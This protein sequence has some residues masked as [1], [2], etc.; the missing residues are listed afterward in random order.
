MLGSSIQ[1]AGGDQLMTAGMTVTNDGTKTT[2]LGKSGDYNRVGDAGTTG[3]SLASEDDLMITGKLEVDGVA[4]FNGAVLFPGATPTITVNSDK[5]L[6]F[7]TSGGDAGE[8]I[9]VMEAADANAQHI[10]LSISPGTANRV[11]VFTV[12]RLTYNVDLGAGGVDL[13]GIIEPTIAAV[14]AASD[15]FASLDAGDING[16]PVGV[17]LYFKAAADEDV[18]LLKLSVT[19]TPSLI[20]DESEDVFTY[21]HGVSALGYLVGTNAGIDES[22]SG[23]ITTFTITIEK[24]IV[25][26]FSKVS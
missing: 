8:A 5:R 18:N 11:P 12:G 6:I 17:G 2:F 25:T 21:S 9:F 26:A 4:Y 19:G 24:G 10:M 3:H 22:G 15:A 13:S 14:N 20:W 1:M 7:G 23:T 16:S